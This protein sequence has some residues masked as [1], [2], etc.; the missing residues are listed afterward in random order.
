M[1]DGQYFAIIL[2]TML[3]GI[4]NLYQIIELRKEFKE[5]RDAKP[6]R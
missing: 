2:I 6:R 1:T 5:Y 3:W 4:L